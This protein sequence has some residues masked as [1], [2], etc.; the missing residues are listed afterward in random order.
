[1]A[2]VLKKSLVCP[3]HLGVLVQPLAYPGP[4]PDEPLHPFCREKRVTENL[5]GFLAYAVDTA[6]TLDEPDDRPGEIVIDDHERILKVLPLTENIRGDKDTDLVLFGGPVFGL[7]AL[8]AEKACVERRVVRIPGDTL[9]VVEMKVFAEVGHRVGELRED[10]YLV[11]CVMHGDQ[12]SEFCELTVFGRLPLA[13]KL[14]DGEEAHGIVPQVLREVFYEKVGAQPVKVTGMFFSED[15]IDYT[16]VGGKIIQRE[17]FLGIDYVV[18]II[19]PIAFE[20]F[21]EIVLVIDPRV[22][23]SRVL[24]PDRQWEPVL[25]GVENDEVSQ[26]VTA[27]GK[28]KGVAATSRRLKRFVRQKPRRRLPALERFL[29]ISPSSAVGGLSESAFR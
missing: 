1:M 17:A 5:L 11:A 6:G 12:L 8:G 21:S 29:M 4:E 13:G 26:D 27:H 7:V 14:K 10:E 20:E 18:R 24:S 16:G 2:F 28:E 9:E 3:D 22:E 23:E 15:C 25:D 19:V